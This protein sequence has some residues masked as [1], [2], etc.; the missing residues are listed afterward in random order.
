MTAQ[1]VFVLT[2]PSS[3]AAQS[4]A[5]LDELLRAG[6]TVVSTA[7]M[8]AGGQAV[9]FASVVVLE[10]ANA[11]AEGLLEQIEDAIEAEPE[12]AGVQDPLLRRL[13]DD[14]DDLGPMEN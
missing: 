13:Q 2:H 7:P 5:A 9:G 6:W 14:A 1:K 10:Q 4:L 12:S 8:G 11:M 3:D